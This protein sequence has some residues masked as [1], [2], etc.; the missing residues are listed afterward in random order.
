MGGRLGAVVFRAHP[1]DVVEVFAIGL[2]V[3]N[4]PPDL[5]VSLYRGLEIHLRLLGQA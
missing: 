4:A 1:A 2:Q 5:D 3:G